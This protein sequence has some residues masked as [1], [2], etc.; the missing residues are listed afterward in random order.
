MTNDI[1]DLGYLWFKLI[2][3]EDF[4]NHENGILK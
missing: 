4:C 3:Q 2:L 1:E